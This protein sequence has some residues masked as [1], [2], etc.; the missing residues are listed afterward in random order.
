MLETH[1]E[2][3]K[4]GE[5][6]G[7]CRQALDPCLVELAAP[8]EGAE[9]DVEVSSCTQ[10]TQRATWGGRRTARFM[11]IPQKSGYRAVPPFQPGACRPMHRE[12]ERVPAGIPG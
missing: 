1:G 12:P 6:S 2:S 4:P 11:P 10:R 3:A 5:R 9:L 7:L 8:G